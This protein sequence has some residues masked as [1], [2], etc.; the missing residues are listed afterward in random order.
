MSQL[1]MKAKRRVPGSAPC[2]TLAPVRARLECY[3]HTQHLTSIAMSSQSQ[4]V[5]QIHKSIASPILSLPPELLDVIF[6]EYVRISGRSPTL[7]MQVC[8][9]WKNLVTSSGRLWSRIDLA[10]QVAARRHLE[11]SQ[12]SNLDVSWFG[13]NP[14]PAISQSEYRQWMWQYS[15]RFSSLTLNQSPRIMQL[16]F[17]ELAPELPYLTDL[18]LIGQKFFG[19]QRPVPLDVRSHLPLLRKLALMYVHISKLCYSF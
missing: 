2:L 5:T 17:A 15:P 3:R 19:D 6:H 9:R 7:L 13:R 14:G 11:L 16:I 18:L 12:G 10:N 4:H 1:A 8:R